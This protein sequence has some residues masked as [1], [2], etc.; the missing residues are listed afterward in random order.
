MRFIRLMAM[1]VLALGLAACGAPKT[2][3]LKYNGPAVTQLQVHKTDRKMYLLHN[4]KVLKSHDIA[5]GFAPNGHKQFEGD[6][7][8]PRAAI[9]S[10]TKTR[11]RSFICPCGCP[12]RMSRTSPLPRPKANLLGVTSSFMVARSGRFP[13]GTGPGVALLSPTRKWKSSTRWWSPAP[14]SISCPDEASLDGL[15]ASRGNHLSVSSSQAPVIKV[16]QILPL[17][18][19]NH[20][21]PSNLA[22][23]SMMM[24]RVS[25]LAIHVDRVS[26]SVS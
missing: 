2:K 10:P 5:L 11:I 19:W 7:K 17:G 16:H 3:F 1:L 24:A 4:D 15:S 12:I 14:R 22:E 23:G 25:G 20:A 18:S 21:K 13:A 26:S 8:T 6:G 9:T